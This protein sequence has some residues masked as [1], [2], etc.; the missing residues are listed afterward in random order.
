LDNLEL[1]KEIDYPRQIVSEFVGTMLLVATIVGSGIMGDDLS[2]DDGV[3]L[4]GM[5]AATVGMLYILINIF[6]PVSGAH[7][8]PIVSLAF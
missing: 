6:G 1:K 3:A 5:T 4:L 7:F 2:A 8:N